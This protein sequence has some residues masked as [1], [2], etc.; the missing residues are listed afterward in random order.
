MKKI[1]I[2]I[3][4]LG[5]RG[6]GLSHTLLGFENCE[7]RAVCDVYADRVEELQKLVKEKRGTDAF[8]TLDYK[9]V[10]TRDGIDAIIISTSWESHIEIATAAMRAG[11]PVGMEVG[12][13]YSVEDCFTLVRTQ[14]ETGT[15]FMFLENCCYGRKELTI[16][17][18]VDRKAHV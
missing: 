17:N 14:V 10:L 1:G 2:G 11:V 13:A 4:G 16:L 9:E 12:G 15:K 3:I 7:I 18:M 8:G 5:G 6:I